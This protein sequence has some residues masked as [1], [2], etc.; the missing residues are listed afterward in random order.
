[1]FHEV[2]T[3][4]IVTVGDAGCLL[5]TRSQQQTGIFDPAKRKDVSVRAG[6]EI[7]VPVSVWHFSDETRAALGIETDIGHIRLHDDADVFGF[8]ENAPIHSS[9]SVS[10]D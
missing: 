9:Q 4:D 6:H 1:M 8:L 3:D 2:S 7:V 10:A 5:R